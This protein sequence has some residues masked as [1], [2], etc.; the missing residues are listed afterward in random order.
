L[1]TEQLRLAVAEFESMDMQPNLT[2]ARELLRTVAP[3]HSRRLPEK[4]DERDSVDTLT[5]R[6]REVAALLSQG[7]SNREIATTLVISQSTAEVHVK[8]VLSK[9]GLRSRSQ[10]AAWAAERDRRCRPSQ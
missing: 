5:K 8:H 3:A 9:L 6:E 7:M 10:V 2:R 1:A 4:S